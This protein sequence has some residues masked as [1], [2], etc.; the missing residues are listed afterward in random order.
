[1]LRVRELDND[2]GYDVDMGKYFPSNIY[3]RRIIIQADGE[4][5]KFILQDFVGIK[6]SRT[7]NIQIFVGEDAKFIA[8]NWN[9]IMLSKQ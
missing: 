1:M 9:L 4:E 7:A 2:F 3:D 8:A 6:K 5:L